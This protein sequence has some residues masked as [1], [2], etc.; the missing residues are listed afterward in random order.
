MIVTVV[1]LAVDRGELVCEQTRTEQVPVV[2]TT[3]GEKPGAERKVEFV[4]RI[5]TSR[6]KHQLKECVFYSAAGKKLTDDEARKR[7]TVGSAVLVSVGQLPGDAYRN[8]LRDDV[9]ILVSNAPVVL[10]TPPG[11]APGVKPLPPERIR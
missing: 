5:V 10:P 3:S 11:P 8:I 7:L 9:V 4:T 6:T 1:E 2:K